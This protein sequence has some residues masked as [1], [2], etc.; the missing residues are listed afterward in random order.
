MALQKHEVWTK[1]IIP[2]GASAIPTRFLFQK[3]FKLNG[4]V[5]RCKAQLVVKGYL[6]GEVEGTFTPVVDFTTIRTEL[7]LA[8]QRGYYVH[9]MD[10][11]TAF[12]NERWTKRCLLLHHPGSIFAR[13]LRF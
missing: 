9:Q 4:A 6:Q 1:A 2:P 8:V 10:I 11:K 3:K 12:F 7:A 5:V 13:R